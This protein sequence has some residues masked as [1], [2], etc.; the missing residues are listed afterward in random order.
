MNQPAAPSNVLQATELNQFRCRLMY[1]ARSQGLS[2]AD[3][4]DSV[5]ATFAKLVKR[6][7]GKG[8]VVM[9]QRNAWSYIQTVHHSVVIDFLR[10]RSAKRKEVLTPTLED[11]SGD[12][13]SELWGDVCREE[14]V[15]YLDR[16]A[17]KV[18]ASVAEL[19]M[20]GASNA[21][22]AATLGV[23]ERVVEVRLVRA[24]NKIVE[25]LRS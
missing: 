10:Q 1:L 9:F 4:E 2:D 6:L 8:E 22:I 24:R 15:E 23:T 17:D 25:Y 21:K 20:M 16:T 13:A 14:W 7:N 5:Q 11:S 18:T 19:K 12:N 3:A